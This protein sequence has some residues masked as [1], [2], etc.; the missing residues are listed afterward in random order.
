M[1]SKDSR[2]KAQAPPKLSFWTF[3]TANGEEDVKEIRFIWRQGYR[4]H[5]EI[6]MGTLQRF[7][8]SVEKSIAEQAEEIENDL[9]KPSIGRTDEEK[10]FLYEDYIETKE[11]FQKILK[12]CSFVYSF[13]LFERT[14]VRIIQHYKNTRKLPSRL[15]N[16]SSFD[17]IHKVLKSIVGKEFPDKGKEWPKIRLLKD[18]RNQIVH[19]EG[20]LPKN[21]RAACMQSIVEE[22]NSDSSLGNNYTFEFSETFISRVQDIFK[23]FLCNLFKVLPEK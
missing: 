14:L 3:C 10:L 6:Q 15:E 13:S 18:I 21:T 23:I 11:E 12:Y 20:R 5:I 16:L 17:Q 19:H 8:K 9:D 4:V 22:L 1:G 7:V 2:P